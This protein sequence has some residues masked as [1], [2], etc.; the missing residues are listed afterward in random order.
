MR[1][2]LIV[3]KKLSAAALMLLYLSSGD[4]WRRITRGT[5]HALAQDL[6]DF[7]RSVPLEAAQYFGLGEALARA[8]CCVQLRS[9]VAPQTDQGDYPQRP[10]GIAIAA[11]V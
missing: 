3:A 7:A 8:A 9:W 6:E 5:D 11:A 4:S 10:V 1:S 2:A